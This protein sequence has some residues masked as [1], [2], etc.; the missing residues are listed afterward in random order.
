MRDFLCVKVKSIRDVA[1][2]SQ[3]QSRV[4]EK[5]KMRLNDPGPKRELFLN[6]M[7][8]K[9]SPLYFWG[10]AIVEPQASVLENSCDRNNPDVRERSLCWSSYVLSI[11]IALQ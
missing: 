8:K 11:L 6:G 10:P 4:G 7:L 2:C 5:K 3:S 1:P 9:L